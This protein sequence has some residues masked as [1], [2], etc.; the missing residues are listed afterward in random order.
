M[1]GMKRFSLFVLLLA[2]LSLSSLPVAQTPSAAD[3]IGY[4]GARAVVEAHPQFARVKELPG[5]AEA[6][7]EPLRAQVQ[8]LEAKLRSG[9][10]T[11]QEQQSYRAAVQ[12]LEVAVQNWSEQQNTAP[13]PIT[14]DIDKIIGR[15]A[16]EQ[17]FAILLEQEGPPAVV[18]QCMPRRNST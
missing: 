1:A 8:L 18:W 14:E 7:L 3:K 6:E 9:N 10:A 4:L 2:G 15:V 11:S 17:G 16:K 5:K 12:S 13:R